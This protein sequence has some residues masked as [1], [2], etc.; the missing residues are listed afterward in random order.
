MGRVDVGYEHP[1]IPRLCSTAADPSRYLVWYTF[2]LV[3]PNFM[4]NFTD[5]NELLMSEIAADVLSSKNA[6]MA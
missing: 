5:G 6:V 4:L 2:S 1:A 3:F